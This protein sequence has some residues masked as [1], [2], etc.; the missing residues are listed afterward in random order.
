VKKRKKKNVE[1]KG[2]NRLGGGEGG[3]P[4]EG[5]FLSRKASS[6][7]DRQDLEGNFNEEKKRVQVGGKGKGRKERKGPLKRGNREN[8][9][10]KRVLYN[11]EGRRDRKGTTRIRRP[12]SKIRGKKGSERRGTWKQGFNRGVREKILSH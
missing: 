7:Y 1:E 11:G 8:L 5:K 12:L 3:L 4:R 2:K 6:I 9:C 10:E